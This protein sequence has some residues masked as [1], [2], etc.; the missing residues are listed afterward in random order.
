[1]RPALRSVV[2][3]CL[4]VAA[5]CAGVP[6]S[7][8]VGAQPL[9]LTIRSEPLQLKLDEPSLFKIG[10]LIWRGG[11]SMTGSSSNFGG[12]SD[13]HISPDGRTLTTIS[14][15]GSWLTATIEYDSA[16]NLAGLDHARIGSLRGLDG[17]P[18]ASKVEADSEGMAHMP[19]GSWLV[20]FERD[21][22]IWRYPTLDGTPVAI[23][24]PED[25]SRQPLNGGVEALTALPDGRIVAISEEHT[26]TPKLLVGWIGQPEAEGRYSWQTFQYAKI[27]DFNPTALA[28]L[29]DGGFVM[30]ERAFDM[31]HGVRIRVMRFDEAELKPGATI[32]AR[33]LARLASPLAVDNLEGIAA[34]KG[35]RGETLLWLIS[36]DNFSSLQRDLL[37]LFE[38]EK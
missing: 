24:L 12:W 2:G 18:L 33:E 13:L 27:P 10:K 4:L 6:P 1:M 23:N 16:D 38:L 26:L 37:L 35:T 29:P 20:S 14:D 3:F 15:L 32:N 5:A 19:D 25:F 34:T 31:V 9:D 36:D 8:P 28:P 22:R 21:H 7:S 11:I 17:N 30:L